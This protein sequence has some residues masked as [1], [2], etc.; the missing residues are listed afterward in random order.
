MKLVH[1]VDVICQMGGIGYYLGKELGSG[2]IDRMEEHSEEYPDHT[3]TVVLLFSGERLIG[4]LDN[5]P[6]CIEYK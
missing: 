5:V 4:K 3:D 2:V 1:R 6:M